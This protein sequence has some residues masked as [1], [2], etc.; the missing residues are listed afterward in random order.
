MKFMRE[1]SAQHMYNRGDE[2]FKKS[3]LENLHF[4]FATFYSM[5]KGE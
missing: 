3:E 1:K 2:L 4:E 5:K